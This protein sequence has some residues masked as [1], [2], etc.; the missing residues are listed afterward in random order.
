GMHYDVA[1]GRQFITGIT[2]DKNA[3]GATCLCFGLGSLW[4]LLAAYRD[5]DD[6][7]RTRLLIVHGT[8]LAMVVWLFLKANSMTSLVCFVLGSGLIVATSVSVLARKRV[9]VNLLVM[10]VVAVV[11]VSLFVDIG[12]GVFQT[13]G[14][15]ATLT[16]R[17][18]IWKQA[19]AV[20]N[21]PIL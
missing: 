14:R 1:Q 19:L 8:L 9:L 2:T 3:L 7:H 21:N 15:D 18:E 20:D 5:R 10:T 12:T 16:G 6:R 13:I 11:A 4:R 17:T